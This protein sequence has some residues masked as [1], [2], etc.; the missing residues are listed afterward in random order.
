VVHEVHSTLAFFEDDLC[1]RHVY[2]TTRKERQHSEGNTINSSTV[3]TPYKACASTNV[4]SM[5]IKLAISSL[6]V[7]NLI[8]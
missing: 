2:V 1:E 3:N 5:N 4:W 7:D 8:G 6:K